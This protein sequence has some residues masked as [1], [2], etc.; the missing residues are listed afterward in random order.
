MI[1]VELHLMDAQ[2]AAWFATFSDALMQ[3]R[4]Q[5]RRA[6]QAEFH[7]ID[8]TPEPEA[9]PEAEVEP[10]EEPEPQV[11]GHIAPTP[12]LAELTAAVQ[13]TLTGETMPA[14]VLKVK[15]LLEQYGAKVLSEVPEDKR[16]E[17]IGSL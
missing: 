3:Y 1:K 8:A 5:K 11:V 16:A 12:T 6:Q 10:G 15:R 17:L 13:A 9:A 14:Q 4:A 2:E 7:G